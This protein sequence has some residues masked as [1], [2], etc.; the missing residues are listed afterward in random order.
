MS[1]IKSDCCPKCENTEW[2]EG[3]L[4]PSGQLMN[5]GFCPKGKFLII[6]K[7]KIKVRACKNCG[8]IEM[9]LK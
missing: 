3:N 8:Y 9:F 1:D 5:V 6:K 4:Q 7:D 2:Q